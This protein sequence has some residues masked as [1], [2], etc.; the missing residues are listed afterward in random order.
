L[1]LSSTSQPAN[2]PPI[3]QPANPDSNSG[4]QAISATFLR[5]GRR[6]RRKKASFVLHMQQKCGKCNII[7][8]FTTKYDDS[9]ATFWRP[10]AKKLQK[11]EKSWN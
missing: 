10:T 8:A 2:Q 5:L 11:M 1:P 9:E 3:N 6:R 4:F 7:V